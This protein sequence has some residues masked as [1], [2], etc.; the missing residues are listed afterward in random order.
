MVPMFILML[1]TTSVDL[2]GLQL[3]PCSLSTSFS[4]CMCSPSSYFLALAS[5]SPLLQAALGPSKWGVGLR[6]RTLQP[7]APDTLALLFLAENSA[8]TLVPLSWRSSVPS[9]CVTCDSASE[10]WDWPSWLPACSYS[11]YRVS[12][13]QRPSCPLVTFHAGSAGPL[14][15]SYRANLSGFRK[16]EIE[17][18]F[19]S[20]FLKFLKF[21]TNVKANN[22][23][24]VTAEIGNISLEPSVPA[25]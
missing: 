16:A 10:T 9:M 17:L 23:L 11:L 21:I 8:F 20:Y 19:Y 13:I 24:K 22:L 6:N 4:L 5:G 14:C 3:P 1:V 15:P 2:H 7:V 12:P 25:G 18:Y